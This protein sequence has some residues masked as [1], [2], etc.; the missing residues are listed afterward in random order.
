[1]STASKASIR[2]EITQHQDGRLSLQIYV[3]G[4][5]VSDQWIDRHDVWYV[6]RG[7]EQCR[8]PSCETL[9]SS[10]ERRT[11]RELAQAEQ[12]WSQADVLASLAEQLD[13]ADGPMEET[14]THQLA[15]CKPDHA[16]QVLEWAERA[17]AIIFHF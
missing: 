3:E 17:V 1:M 15:E 6:V 9:R 4:E 10:W 7:Q 12:E 8:Y 13:Q 2:G 16:E 5:L 14:D 11:R